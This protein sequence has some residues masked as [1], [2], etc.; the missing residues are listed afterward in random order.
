MGWYHRGCAMRSRTRST[1]RFAREALACARAAVPGFASK[2][3]KRR[4]SQHQLLAI[5]ALR[6]FLGLDY[7]SME[8]MLAEWSDLR[9]VLGLGAVPD[10]STLCLASKRLLQESSDKKGRSRA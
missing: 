9:E 3:S 8:Q 1:L 4:F 10:Y 5:L 7:R 2:F 6:K